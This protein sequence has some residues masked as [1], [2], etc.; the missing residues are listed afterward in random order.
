MGKILGHDP[1]TP[2]QR[3]LHAIFVEAPLE[4][5]EAAAGLVVHLIDHIEGHSDIHIIF[6]PFPK[7]TSEAMAYAEKLREHN[8][9]CDITVRPLN[10]GDDL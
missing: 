5:Y 3:L 1:E 9:E 7:D 6:G 2:A 8:P 4:E 10:R